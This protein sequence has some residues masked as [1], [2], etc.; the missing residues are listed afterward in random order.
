MIVVPKERGQVEP[1]FGNMIPKP[2]KNSH[3]FVIFAQG[4][5]G[6]VLWGWLKFRKG[7]LTPTQK[8]QLKPPNSG[9]YVS[10]QVHLM[11]DNFCCLFSLVDFLERIEI[12]QICLHRAIFCRR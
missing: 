3:C 9:V 5:W 4:V 7:A 10:L 11:L 6:F 12:R 8:F 2:P 1:F